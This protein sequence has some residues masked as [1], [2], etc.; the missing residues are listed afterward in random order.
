MK[1]NAEYL[2]DVC[3]PCCG[4]GDIEGEAVDII[5]DTAQQRVGC[6]VCDASWLDVYQLKR[7]ILLEAGEE[8]T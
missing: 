6:L 3:C 8:E 2:A 1:S 5:G 7:Y 4:S